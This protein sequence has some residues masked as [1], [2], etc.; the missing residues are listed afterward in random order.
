MESKLQSSSA[1]AVPA[2]TNA[3]GLQATAVPYRDVDALQ[4]VTMGRS[5]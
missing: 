5:K 2:R 4:C 3:E 1:P